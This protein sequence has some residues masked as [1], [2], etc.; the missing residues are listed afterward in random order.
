MFRTIT[1]QYPGKC[2]RCRQPIEAGTRIRYGGR[3]MTYH[4]AAQC[5]GATGRDPG[6]RERDAEAEAE[7]RYF[8]KFSADYQMETQGYVSSP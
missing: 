3:G 7:A 2:R 4:F 5:G 1:A 8:E 6:V